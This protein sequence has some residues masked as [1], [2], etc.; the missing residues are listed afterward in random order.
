[1]RMLNLAGTAIV[2]FT[3]TPS[4]H[5][6][7]SGIWRGSGTR[8]IDRAALTAVRRMHYPPFPGTENRTFTV[9]IRI[10]P[11]SGYGIGQP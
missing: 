1:M 2:E 4:G 9:P 6:V 10:A 7:A 3:L 5:L 8:S 11:G